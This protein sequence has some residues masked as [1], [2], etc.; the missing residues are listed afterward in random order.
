MIAAPS[1]AMLFLL[2]SMSASASFILRKPWMKRT[3]LSL[4]AGEILMAAFLWV[5]VLV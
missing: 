4:A 5:L 2:G 3:V 1:I